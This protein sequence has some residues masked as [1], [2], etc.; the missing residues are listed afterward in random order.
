MIDCERFS[1]PRTWLRASS[2]LKRFNLT[3]DDSSLKRAKNIG[4]M[5]SLVFA[6]SMS[7]HKAN[8]F[9]ARELLTY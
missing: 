9:S 6:L 3:S 7:E 1:I 2:L 5:C 8:T 4:R